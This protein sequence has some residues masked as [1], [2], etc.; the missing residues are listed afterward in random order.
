MKI[1]T[2]VFFSISEIIDNGYWYNSVFPKTSQVLLLMHWST[3]I[4]LKMVNWSF[5][6]NCKICVEWVTDG[7]VQ[8]RNRMLISTQNLCQVH[9]HYTGTISVSWTYQYQCHA[10]G[11]LQYHD[12]I[13]NLSVP[14]PMSLRSESWSWSCFASFASII[15]I[16]WQGHFQFQDQCHMPWSLV[17]SSVPWIVP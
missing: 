16:I 5:C 14:W 10:H 11:T 4:L 12:Q 3:Y 7:L 13:M 15:D 2:V 6:Q 9:T 8:C 1:P 17:I